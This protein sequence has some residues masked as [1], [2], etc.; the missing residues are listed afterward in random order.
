MANPNFP[1]DNL[2]NVPILDTEPKQNSNFGEFAT[3]EKTREEITVQQVWHNSEDKSKATTW[4]RVE[5][6]GDT[7]GT[8]LEGTL[9]MTPRKR[10]Y[11]AQKKKKLGKKVGNEGNK[12]C[13]IQEVRTYTISTTKVAIQPHR[14]Q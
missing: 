9:G 4:K 8:A 7:I 1:G 2:F 5:C 11:T 6:K 13:K 12:R 14:E 3:E 10:V